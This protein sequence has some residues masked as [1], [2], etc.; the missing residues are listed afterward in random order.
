MIMA[1]V[2]KEGVWDAAVQCYNQVGIVFHMVKITFV[3]S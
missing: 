1:A 3:F 2:S